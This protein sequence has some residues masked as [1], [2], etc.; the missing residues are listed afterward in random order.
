MTAIMSKQKRK[1]VFSGDVA[2]LEAPCNASQSHELDHYRTRTD[3][4]ENDFSS[5]EKG[6]QNVYDDFKKRSGYGNG[7]I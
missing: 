4:K 1:R 5:G 3:I 6:C 2:S 7:D